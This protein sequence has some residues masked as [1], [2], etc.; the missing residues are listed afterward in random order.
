MR[1]GILGLGSMNGTKNILVM[2][3]LLGYISAA[4]VFITCAKHL[5]ILVTVNRR[6]DSRLESL[7]SWQDDLFREIFTKSGQ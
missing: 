2:V 7:S 5:Q 3:L 6:I 1:Y 4:G